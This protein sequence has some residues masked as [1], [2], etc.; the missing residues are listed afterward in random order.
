ME[1]QTPHPPKSRMKPR[2]GQN[3][4]I[5]PSL[6]WGGEGGLGFPFILS[7]IQPRPQGFYLKK[8]VGREKPHPFFKGKALGTRLVQ[9]C[10][11]VT[12]SYC[13]IL[14]ICGYIELSHFFVITSPLHLAVLHFILLVMVQTINC[15]NCALSELSK[16]SFTVTSIVES[17]SAYLTIDTSSRLLSVSDHPKTN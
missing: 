3:R 1:Q 11:K 16:L 14:N 17:L 2:E 10:S 9:D 13:L 8:W 12:R 4:I 5:F 15:A 6:I 7:T